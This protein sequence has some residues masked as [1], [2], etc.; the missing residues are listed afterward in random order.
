MGQYLL[1]KISP[2]FPTYMG[3]EKSRFVGIKVLRMNSHRWGGMITDRHINI[4]MLLPV[5]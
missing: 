3:G 2:A 4:G 5:I 1:L